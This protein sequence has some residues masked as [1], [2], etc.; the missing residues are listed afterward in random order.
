VTGEIPIGDWGPL[1]AAFEEFL[2]GAGEV[3]AGEGRLSFTAGDPP[4]SLVLGASGSL[5]AG[6]PLHTIDGTVS[7]VRFDREADEIRFSGPG[8]GYTYRIPPSLRTPKDL[9]P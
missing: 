9:R 2:A 6:M 8:F 3:V 1:A 4:T 7:V 5:S